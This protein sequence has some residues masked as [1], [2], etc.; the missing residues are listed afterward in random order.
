MGCCCGHSAYSHG[1][2]D[3]G[4]NEP[5]RGEIEC[6]RCLCPRFHFGHQTDPEWADVDDLTDPAEIA[7][8]EKPLTLCQTKGQVKP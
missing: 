5:D 7:L 8:C 2:D 4:R 6:R 3:S 1:E